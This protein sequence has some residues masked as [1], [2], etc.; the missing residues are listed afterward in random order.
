[1]SEIAAAAGVGKGTLYRR[2]ASKGEL[3]LSLLDQ[4]MSDFQNGMLARF[5]NQTA[6][7]VSYL[8]QLS[9]FLEALVEFTE[10]HSP[11]LIEVQ[12]D[13]IS[14]GDVRLNLPHFWQYMTVS[15]LLR[16]AARHDEISPGFDLDFLGEALLAPLSI[17][18][19]SFQRRIRGYSTERIG[20][21]LRSLVD[22][23]A[24]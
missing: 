4:Q 8:E 21:G 11:L 13:G 9:R 7:G 3:C 15:A 19:F 23:L 18:N 1:M 20:A 17:D 10:I 14:Q 24:S 5:Q 12:R 2:F 22:L 6:Q 16:S